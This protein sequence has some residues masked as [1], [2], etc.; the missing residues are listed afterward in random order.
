MQSWA[1]VYT[2]TFVKIPLS[3]LHVLPEQGFVWLHL[4][5][6][7]FTYHLPKIDQLTGSPIHS[8]HYRDAENSEH[9]SIFDAGNGYEVI[10]WRGIAWKD[11]KE[12]PWPQLEVGASTV[13]TLL[14]PKLLVTISDANDPNVD[15]LEAFILRD[16]K[17]D[18][19]STEELLYWFGNLFIEQF[20]QL[21]PDLNKVTNHWQRMLLGQNR[22]NYDSTHFLQFKNTLD[23]LHGWAMDIEETLHDLRQY[24]HATKQTMLN[25]NINDLEDHIQRMTKATERINN[26]LETLIH[27]HFAS[28]SNRSNVI[29][30]LLAIFSAIFLPLMLI[31]GIFGMNFEN[32]GFLHSEYGYHLTLVIMA[33][34]ALALLIVFRWKKW[35]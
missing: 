28:L 25:I 7:E 4:D 3:E 19:V 21:R 33:C 5:R 23:Q 9:P 31:T 14:Y 16:K 8:Q 29:L 17:Q 27:L 13:A 1:F 34:I 6:N 18:I 12:T 15:R 2:Q 20:L 22:D 10:V 26:S 30:R 11:L 24:N 35:L 32:M